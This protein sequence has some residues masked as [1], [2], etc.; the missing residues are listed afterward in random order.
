MTDVY[1]LLS[2][3]I[4]DEVLFSWQTLKKLGV[5]PEEFPLF[6]VKAA[7]VTMLP[8]ST[9]EDKGETE[10]VHAVNGSGKDAREAQD[11]ITQMIVEFGTVF[12]QEGQLKISFGKLKMSHCHK[13]EC[14]KVGIFENVPNKNITYRYI[15]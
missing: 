11:A 7:A 10:R 6:S 1:A 5:I 8:N 4:C 2:S 15:G 12:N 13:I 9:T 3:S 14:I